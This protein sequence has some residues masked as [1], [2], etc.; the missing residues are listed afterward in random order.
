MINVGEKVKI[1]TGK[2]GRPSYAIVIEV[3]VPE[4]GGEPEEYKVMRGK[5]SFPEMFKATELEV[6]ATNE[7]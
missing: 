4:N 3:M 1:K 6:I 7:V 5:N 2:R